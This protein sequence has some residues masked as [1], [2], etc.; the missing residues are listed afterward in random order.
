[1]RAKPFSEIGDQPVTAFEDLRD[2]NGR[3]G[4]FKGATDRA[5]RNV[6]IFR[7][8]EAAR[9]VLRPSGTEP[10]AKAYVEVCSPPCT[11][12]TPEDSWRRACLEADERTKRVANDFLQKALGLVGLKAPQAALSR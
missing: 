2:E 8:G 7:L 9:V 4:P 5:A 1:M 12:R 6:L 3:M 10:K 11:P